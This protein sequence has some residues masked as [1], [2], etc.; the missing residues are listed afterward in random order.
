[1]AG[2]I[3]LL[4][5]IFWVHSLPHRASDFHEFPRDMAAVTDPDVL[6]SLPSVSLC[7]TGPVYASSYD[8][9]PHLVP[10][11]PVVC[12]LA[13]LWAVVN[14]SFLVPSSVKTNALNQPFSYFF[15]HRTEC[16]T[17]TRNMKTVFYSFLFKGKPSN[18]FSGKDVSRGGWNDN[19]SLS[20]WL[21]YWL[22][23]CQIFDSFPNSS[24]VVLRSL[25]FCFIWFGFVLL[26]FPC[27][28]LRERGA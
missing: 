5:V 6:D 26:C 13:V 22:G 27:F 20:R 9:L 17:C 23:S 2:E 3:R 14:A 21:F 11:C 8:G 25:C 15:L 28:S 16:C 4:K 12:F 18:H 1:M 7:F 10:S 19:V 24:N